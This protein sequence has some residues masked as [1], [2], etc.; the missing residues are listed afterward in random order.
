MP[1]GGSGPVP[2]VPEQRAR[3]A[4]HGDGDRRHHHAPAK[5]G[6][7]GRA[8]R[9]A[10]AGCLE[11]VGRGCCHGAG[12]LVRFRVPG[13]QWRVASGM[14]AHAPSRD[15][16]AY[17]CA[18]RGDSE[19]GHAGGAR[20]ARARHNSPPRLSGASLSGA[21]LR[22]LGMRAPLPLGAPCCMS[23]NAGFAGL[24]PACAAAQCCAFADGSLSACLLH[25]V[26]RLVQ[27]AAGCPGPSSCRAPLPNRLRTFSCSVR[28]RSR[29][30]LCLEASASC[31]GVVCCWGPVWSF[32]IVCG[33]H[34]SRH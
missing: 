5:V 11:S 24:G 6:Q 3:K 14:R 28:L 21:G 18:W 16:P 12:F 7:Q 13:V 8:C 22:A 17:R 15:W 30:R 31:L 29:L 33:L 34:S 2:A 25:M 32:I 10:K 9:R 1:G 23:P 27:G 26:L 4:A 20:R 19:L